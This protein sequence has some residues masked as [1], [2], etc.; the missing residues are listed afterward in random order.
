MR[1]CVF[2]GC[3]ETYDRDVWYRGVRFQLCRTHADRLEAYARGEAVE[4]LPG[5]RAIFDVEIADL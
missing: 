4:P 3:R 1:H 2:S 5:E